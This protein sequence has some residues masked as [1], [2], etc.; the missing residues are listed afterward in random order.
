MRQEMQTIRGE[1]VAARVIKNDWGKLTLRGGSSDAATH[2]VT[3]PVLGI[4]VGTT[5]E[6]CGY[7]EEHPQ[8]GRQ[9]KAKTIVTVIPSDAS[10]AIAWLASKLPAVGRKRATLLVERY[11]IPALWTVLEEDAARLVEVPGITPAA[12]TA[13]GAEYNRVKGDR[14]ELVQL[15]GW[16]LTESQIARCREAWGR[17]IITRLRANPYEL[18][19][20]VR[21]F[22]FERADEVARRMGI[23]QDHPGRA[24]AAVL[25]LLSEAEGSGHA[26]VLRE[27]IVER[28]F[29]KLMV[30]R[31]ITE[32]AIADLVREEV[33]IDDDGC[34]YRAPQHR[35]ECA[36]AEGIR[37]MLA[38]APAS[39]ARAA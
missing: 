14:E 33:V 5:V 17:D 34:L 38:L 29:G 30:A 3:G 39:E 32:R 10:G 8:Y 23:D 31:R 24:R 2:T 18:F 6:C 13:I 37:T 19:E 22:G 12:A 15:R 7:I 21:G 27:A 25:F 20:A 9:F 36:I 16:G 1:V 35:A 4:D 26:Y 11:G 28:A